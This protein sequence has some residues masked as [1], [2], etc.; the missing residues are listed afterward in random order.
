MKILKVQNLGAIEEYRLGERPL[1][2]PQEF[3]KDIIYKDGN[4]TVI[5]SDDKEGFKTFSGLP[6]EYQEFGEMKSKSNRMV[7]N[8][9]ER[10]FGI[11]Q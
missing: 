9:L 3:I 6:C 11:L 4:Y 10:I 1:T 8:F 2:V 5:F 7:K